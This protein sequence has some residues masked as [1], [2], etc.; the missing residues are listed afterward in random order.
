[1]YLLFDIGGTKMRI[2]L[3]RDGNTCEEPTVVQT[4]DNFDEGMNTFQRVA[5][6]L[7][8]EEKIIAAAGGIAGPFDHEKK[9]LVNSPHLPGW[10]GKPIKDRLEEILKVSVFLRNDT[11]IVGLGE[12][13]NGAGK[14][15]EIVA[16]ITISTGVGGVRIIDGEIARSQFGFEIGHQIIDLDGSACPTCEKPVDLES[17][18]SGSATERR[19][20]VKPHEITDNKEWNE[21]AKWLAYGLNNT[22]VH[23]S[24]NVIVL[25]G[26]M[27]VKS[28]GIRLEDV[29]EH[30]ARILTIFPNPPEIKQAELGDFGGLY[31]ALMYVKQQLGKV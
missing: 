1:M 6:E 15:Y 9:C 5:K 24:P 21:I 28:P 23:W 8:G 2:A 26:S 27:V 10:T 19:L 12:A 29:R 25:G 4:P 16:Y 14:G 17:M 20:G 13:H 18:I 31:G 30:L 3:S 7:C 11:A 22:I